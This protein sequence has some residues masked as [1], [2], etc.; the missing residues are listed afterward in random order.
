M[1][2][3]KTKTSVLQRLTHLFLVKRVSNPKKFSVILYILKFLHD[4]CHKI[5]HPAITVNMYP[6]MKK[7][8]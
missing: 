3:T 6:C 1:L 5:W 4:L 2:F 8:T 7:M